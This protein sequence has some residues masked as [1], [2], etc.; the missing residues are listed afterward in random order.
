[1]K[2]FCGNAVEILK[3]IPDESVNCCVT[4]PPYFN[5]RD[6]GARG[7]IGLEKSPDDYINKLTEIFSEVRRIL[8]DDGTLW[9]NIADSY[10]GSYKGKGAVPCG[11]QK[12]NIGSLENKNLQVNLRGGGIKPKDMIGIPWLLAF[13][14]RNAGWYL[15]SDIIWH[16]TNA[17]PNPV[18]DRPIS[19]YEHIFLLTKSEKY[20]FNL[21]PLKE[22]VAESTLN[23]IKYPFKSDKYGAENYGQKPQPIQL[24]RKVT[25]IPE[26]RRGRDVWSFGKNCGRLK[27]YAAYPVKLA[28]RCIMAGCPENGIVLD[29]F[30]GSGTTGEAAVKNKRDCILID[31]NQ[32]YCDMSEKRISELN[33]QKE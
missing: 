23:R 24:P 5:L 6:Y 28:E 25:E 2:I 21:E 33:I 3:T 29:P 7:Q 10:G 12:T 27:H 18:K 8:K 4:S 17:M 22:P 30:C 31:I 13:A 26:T 19:C 11:K 14:L 16:K 9:L 1:M 32:K 15:R 20:Y